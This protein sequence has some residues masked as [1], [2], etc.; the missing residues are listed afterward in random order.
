MFKLKTLL[1]PLLMSGVA[2][3]AHAETNT[4]ANAAAQMQMPA[5]VVNKVYDAMV[6]NWQGE[7]DMMGNKV[8]KNLKVHWGLNHQF[9]L[10]DVKSSNPKDPKMKYDGMGVFTVDADGKAKTFWFDSFGVNSIS[11]GSGTFSDNKLEMTS[12][13]TQMKG[14]YTF[15]FKGKD[16]VMNAKGTEMVNGKETPFEFTTVYK[17]K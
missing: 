5:P 8:H 2:L 4:D 15:E 13:N 9:L 1:L 3:T 10:L 12:S 6:G 7:S 17:K 14:T 16:L 11:T